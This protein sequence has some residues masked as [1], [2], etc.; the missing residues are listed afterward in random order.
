LF[1]STRFAHGYAEK[2]RR[3]YRCTLAMLR[4]LHYA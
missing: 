2:A 4:L 3:K 1:S